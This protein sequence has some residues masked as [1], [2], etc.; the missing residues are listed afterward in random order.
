[1]ALALGFFEEEGLENELSTA[2]G[3]DNGAAALISGA[4]DVGF[5]GPEAAV[6]IY[7]QGASDHIVGFAQLT[8]RDGSFF[9]TRDMEEEFTW[10]NVRGKT[11]VGAR[12]G[13]VPQM[14]LEWVLKQHGIRP[15]EDGEI[16]TSL[17]FEAPSAPLRLDLATT[18]PS[19]NRP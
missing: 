15:F 11:I 14:T 6:Y 17:A 7:Q 4:G 2:W 9:M 19:S 12:I 16:I 8:A 10:D 18:L 13:G 1:M 5:F 3:A